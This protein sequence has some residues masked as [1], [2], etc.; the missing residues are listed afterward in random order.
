MLIAD[1]VL[2]GGGV[3]GLALAGAVS[4]LGEAGYTFPRVAGSSAGAIAGA[5]T[6]ALQA[7]GEP[8][9][10]LPEL[11]LSLDYRRL[12]DRSSLGRIP[13]LGEPLAVL[14]QDGLYR[15]SYLEDFLT[16][17]LGEL[18]VR[19]FADLALPVGAVPGPALPPE[20]AFR[21]VVTASDLSRRGLALLP[22]Q[23]ADYGLEPA[24]F[25]VARAVRASAALPLFF[26]PVRLAGSG[27][28]LVDGGLL[29]NYPF[30]V[31]TPVD[32]PAP[33]L[34]TVGVKLAGKPVGPP[35]THHV[36]GAFDLVLAAVETLL[37]ARDSA[38]VS[39]PA[40][41]AATVF[42]DTSD[43][44]VVDFG[45]SDARKRALLDRGRGAAEAWL[46]R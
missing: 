9:S 15:G 25:P 21:L 19:T 17:A 12:T 18:G 41:Q 3:K 6:A 44:S 34:P 4:A 2:E 36:G 24:T 32:E 33:R 27:V 5:F 31:F 13:L 14:F 35:V 11:A 46:A 40:A 38:Y 22:W 28:T 29:S 8:L 16:G 1:L 43:T 23:L 37:D 7:A 30:G 42:I 26:Q 45:I 39:D 20:S 10:R